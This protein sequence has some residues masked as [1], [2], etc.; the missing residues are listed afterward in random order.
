MRL[1][2]YVALVALLF[3][4]SM[5]C[6][7]ELSDFQRV[8][9]AY[10]A[11]DYDQVIQYLQVLAN[12]GMP[13]AQNNLAVMYANGQGV[14]QNYGTA[15]RLSRVMQRHNIT[16]GWCIIMGKAYHRPRMTLA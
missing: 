7:H 4:N 6:A 3:S 8:Q 5:V 13:E 9:D 14:T 15:K 10:A 12:Q 16:L 2:L 1:R 11:R